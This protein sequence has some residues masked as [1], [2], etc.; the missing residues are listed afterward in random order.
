VTLCVDKP[1]CISNKDLWT[2]TSGG[3]IILYLKN[4]APSKDFAT[5]KKIE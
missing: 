2:I 1:E 3:R 4:D 5:G